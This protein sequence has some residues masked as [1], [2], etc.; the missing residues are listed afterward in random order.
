M[1][2]RTQLLAA[3]PEAAIW[4]ENLVPGTAPRQLAEGISRTSFLEESLRL[5]F[6]S[7]LRKPG[8]HVDCFQ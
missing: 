2:D 5:S 1:N 8:H 4:A 6:T 3:F 7:R